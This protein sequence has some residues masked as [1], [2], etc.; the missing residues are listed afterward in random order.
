LG[1]KKTQR[2]LVDVFFFITA[3]ELAVGVDPARCPRTPFA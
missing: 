1:K 2:S 3:I